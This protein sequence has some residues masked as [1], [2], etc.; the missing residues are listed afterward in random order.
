MKRVLMLPLLT[1]SSGHHHVADAI[2]IE[3]E[4]TGNF[5]CKK[6]ELLSSTFGF[7]ERLVSNVYLKWIQYNP[8][9]YSSVYKKLAK[10][11]VQ[12]DSRYTI[13]EKMFLRSLRRIIR[14]H[15]PVFVVCTHALP[16][17]LL[18][19]LKKSGELT[20]P[21]INV[22]TDFFIND[23]WGKQYIDYHVVPDQA[24]KQ[25]LIHNGVPPDQIHVLGIP[26][27]HSIKS[28]PKRDH[29]EKETY[30]VLVSGGNLGTGNLLKF[31]QQLQSNGRIRYQ[32]LCG[33]NKRLYERIS[34]LQKDW[35]HPLPYID[36]REKMNQLYDEN[37]AIITKP[38][39][40]TV[41]ECLKKRLPIFIYDH[42]PGQEEYNLEHLST[43]QLVYPLFRWRE[44]ERDILQILDDP[45][46]FTDGQ[47][48]IS[49]YHHRIE[50]RT[51]TQVLTKVLENGV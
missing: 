43:Q 41:A 26:V 7:G 35:I 42:L 49:D 44:A 9:L 45:N 32:I 18:E 19:T 5:K 21:I 46:V 16:S 40:V 10:S 14:E 3:L 51:A 30:K 13:F 17:Y 31:I 8:T 27:H 20:V 28:I 15:K 48:K 37:D 34:Q 2:K 39:G 12:S 1:I 36:C 50:Q 23:I 25:T 11:N 38:G 29:I 47:S 24:F 4:Q 6:E 22:Y 33:K